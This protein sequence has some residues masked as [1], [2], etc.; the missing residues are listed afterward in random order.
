MKHPG[1]L[2]AGLDVGRVKHDADG[3]TEGLRRKV[4]SELSADDARVAYT[5]QILHIR[6]CTQRDKNAPC[7]RVT[8]PQMTRILVPCTSFFPR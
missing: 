4:V 7:G 3:G 2:I 1:L 6:T 8:L 5:S